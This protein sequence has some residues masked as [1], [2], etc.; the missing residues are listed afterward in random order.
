MGIY[1]CVLGLLIAFAILVISA[2]SRQRRIGVRLSADVAVWLSCVII[3]LS[4]A[5]GAGAPWKTVA[6]FTAAAAAVTGV[7]LFT[8]RPR[9]LL[10]LRRE[11]RGRAEDRNHDAADSE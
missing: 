4:I 6:G 1:V 2:V 8:V 3:S 5:L 11:K 9:F 10:Y 7:Y